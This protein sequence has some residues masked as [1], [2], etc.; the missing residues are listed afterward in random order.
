MAILLCLQLC[1]QVLEVGFQVLPVLV[2]KFTP[3]RAVIARPGPGAPPFPGVIAPMQPSDSLPYR[4]RLGC[5]WPMTSINTGAC[6]MPPGCRRVCASTRCAS[7][8]TPP[9]SAMPECVE[10][11]A[12]PRPV[13]SHASASP[14][15]FPRPAPG[16]LLRADSTPLLDRA[17]DRWPAR[18]WRDDREDA[19]GPSAPARLAGRPPAPQAPQ[20]CAHAAHA[21]APGGVPRR[22][23]R[24]SGHT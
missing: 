12:S 15:V 11:A 6:S 24:A 23:P 1:V 14:T 3:T 5:P 13:R 7:E 8:T 9:L 2:L 17:G 10:G 19:R 22:P 21:A 16:L 20:Q 4:S 18:A